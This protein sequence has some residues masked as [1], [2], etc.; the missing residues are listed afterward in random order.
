MTYAMYDALNFF[1]RYSQKGTAI[2][3]MKRSL[4]ATFW[5]IA[6]LFFCYYIAN[7]PLQNAHYN[8]ETPLMTEVILQPTVMESR[9]TPTVEITPTP[10]V[11]VPPPKP[12]IPETLPIRESVQM[13]V[14]VFDQ[15]KLGYLSGCEMVSLA[16]LINY[17]TEVDIKTLISQMPRSSDPTEGF[18]GDIHTLRGF[19]VLPMALTELTGNYMGE[20]V[21]MTGG[22]VHDLKKK[23]NSNRPIVIW[24][25][26]LGFNVHAICLTG[27]DEDGFFYNDPWTA[28]KDVSISYT[29]FYEIWNTPIYDRHFGIEYP[30]RL[31][32][33][34]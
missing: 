26:G 14:P 28:A 9:H 2:M 17:E 4:F 5:G 13:D 32:L 24:V 7:L 8:E 22:T 18:R 29:D 12:T 1:L 19:T 27:Y 11:T 15:R 31:A 20:G 23:L 16:M 6:I 30:V 21:D 25:N 34:Y 10:T 33:S 3:I